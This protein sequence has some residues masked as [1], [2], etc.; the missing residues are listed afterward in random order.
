MIEEFISEYLP[1]ILITVLAGLIFFIASLYFLRYKEKSA[2]YERYKKAKETVID[3]L[4][5]SL[6]NKQSISPERIKHLISAAE[7]EQNVELIDSPKSLVE[8]LELRFEKSKHLDTEQQWHYIDQIEEMIAKI[9]R[10]SII[11]SVPLSHGEIL[12]SLKEDIEAE[13]KDDALKG[14]EK[15]STKIKELS[16]RRQIH[17]YPRLSEVN[18]TMLGII[19]AIVTISVSLTFLGGP[20]TPTPM[21]TSTPQTPTLTTHGGPTLY[22]ESHYHGEK[23]DSEKITVYGRAKGTAGTVVEKVT[24]NG[25][26]TNDTTLWSAEVSLHT[27]SNTIT[28]KATDNTGTS[29]EKTIALIFKG[30]PT[31]TL[32]TPTA[33]PTPTKS[34]LPGTMDVDQ[35]GHT[36]Q[37]PTATPTPTKPLL[38]RTG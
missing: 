6:I 23:V 10:E 19:V 15:L 38:P 14:L 30:E 25:V 29:T 2:E 26:P 35:L 8:D 1:S 7:R 20:P 34:I 9:E 24:V 11:S 27:G 31:S 32:Q 36:S 33:M 17:K 18:V 37:T 28:V 21:P 12:I 5:S 3:V 13:K 16:E 4:E 22:I